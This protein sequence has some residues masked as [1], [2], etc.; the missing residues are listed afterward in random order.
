[1]IINQ[2]AA[3]TFRK[4]IIAT[5]LKT[6]VFFQGRHKGQDRKRTARTEK[7]QPGLDF[8]H[9]LVHPDK[10]LPRTK[11]FVTDPHKKMVA[12]RVAKSKCLS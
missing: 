2:A 4:I 3:Y 10:N 8:A 9:F 12:G 1:M 11:F 7:E 5:W 6:V